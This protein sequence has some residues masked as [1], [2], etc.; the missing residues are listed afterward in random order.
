MAAIGLLVVGYLWWSVFPV[1]KILWTSSYVLVAG[2]WSLALLALF[3][4]LIDGRQLRGGIAFFF[5]VIGV[6]AITIYLLH[7]FVPFS[8]ISKLFVGGLMRLWLAAA[9]PILF[10]GALGI[11]WL[12]LLYLYRKGTTLRV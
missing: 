8:E 9:E 3:Y 5:V 7:R 1:N 12:L 2:G 6:N 10:L 11:E 4:Y